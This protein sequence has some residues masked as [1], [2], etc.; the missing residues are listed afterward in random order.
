MTQR[1]RLIGAPTDIGAGTRGASMG[2]EALRVA[3]LQATLE[4]RGLQVKDGG[5][6]SGPPHPRDQEEQPVPAHG[7]LGVGYHPQVRQE[8]LDVGALHEFEAPELHEGN[9]GPHQFD[10]QVEGV[11]PG[12]DEHCDPAQGQALLQTCP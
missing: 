4:G 7:V 11:V 3:G 2:P 6:L 8:V 10:F 1:I 5:N 12:P 9:A